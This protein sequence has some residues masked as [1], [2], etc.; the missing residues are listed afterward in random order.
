MELIL[1][2]HHG[3]LTVNNSR[4]NSARPY[5]NLANYEEEKHLWQVLESGL[6]FEICC[7][8]FALACF[9]GNYKLVEL[10]LN[11]YF[12]R[13]WH[14]FKEKS[15][16]L[17]K[18]LNHYN[19]YGNTPLILA[20]RGWNDH[21]LEYDLCS[22][23]IKHGVDL[24][25]TQQL[26]KESPLMTA[27]KLGSN[28]IVQVLLDN[29]ADTTL[30][31]NV[32]ISPLYA[33][34]LHNNETA[35]KALIETGCDINMGSQ[36]HTSL[37]IATRL[38]HLNIVK[39]LCEAGCDISKTNKYGFSHVYEAALRGHNHVLSYLLQHGGNPN[40][41]DIYGNSP[42][43]AAAVKGHVTCIKLLI[44]GGV[45]L[46]LRNHNRECALSVAL[47]A[48]KAEVVEH[49]LEAGLEVI[50]ASE[51][52]QVSVGNIVTV[53][54]RGMS[55]TIAVLIRG[56]SYLPMLHCIT[57]L[58][59]LRKNTTLIKLL[60]H[61]GIQ[62]VPAILL[63]TEKQYGSNQLPDWLVQMKS[64]ARSLQDCCRI[65]IRKCLQNKVLFKTKQLPLPTDL[66][67]FITLK[68]I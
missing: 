41:T 67:M 34:I 53:L 32:G 27:I 22:L 45:S 17:Y 57:M 2:D 37:F 21:P 42:L 4:Q 61:S 66:K 13:T 6:D 30:C 36:D 11:Y 26:S 63:A 28:Q 49:L 48:G 38:G 56:C 24:N 5:R 3:Q 54:E 64:N 25:I 29:D 8:E 16:T 62:T 55:S 15:Q 7:Q 47:L 52:K 33:A 59:G 35:V 50:P 40:V 39:M 51:D 14:C 10:Y 12:K 46:K 43:H 58:P 68:T 19:E 1:R 18:L 31:D 23:L 65:Q 60:V 44:E 20:I 9:L